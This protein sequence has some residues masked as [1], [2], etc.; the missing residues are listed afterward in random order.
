MT[1][2]QS[3]RHLAEAGRYEELLRQLAAVPWTM[4]DVPETWDLVLRA[5]EVRGREDPDRLAD[6]VLSRMVQFTSYLLARAHFIVGLRIS[7][8]DHALRTTGHADF[9]P[10]LLAKHI[11]ML[12]ELQGHVANLVQAQ[13]AVNRLR[14]LAR[15]GKIRNDRAERA[16]TRQARGIEKPDPAPIRRPGPARPNGQPAGRDDGPADRPWPRTEEVQDDARDR[17]PAPASDRERRWAVLQSKL[18]RVAEAL[19]GQGTLVRKAMPSGRETWAIRYVDASGGKP[20]HRSI[21]I[22]AHPRLVRRAR[23]LLGRYRRRRRWPE[24]IATYVRL[25]ASVG[26]VARR[27]ASR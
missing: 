27:L 11:P 7:Q 24:E 17:V 3:R 25:A 21:Y 5:I 2:R 22:G 8:H 13:A 15:R 16:T 18:D 9:S 23:R 26:A 10:D 14:Q 19:I 12:V 20:I 6:D 1:P 4:I